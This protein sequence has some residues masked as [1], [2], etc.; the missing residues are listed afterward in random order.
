MVH[1]TIFTLLA[2]VKDDIFHIPLARSQKCPHRYQ[3]PRG[4]GF[5]WTAAQTCT[6]T[7]LCIAVRT[8]QYIVQTVPFFFSLLSYGPLLLDS[9]GAELFVAVPC[10]NIRLF[11]CVYRL[12]HCVESAVSLNFHKG[13]A[14][15]H[16]G[17]YEALMSSALKESSVIRHFECSD[18]IEIHDRIISDFYTELSYL[19]TVRPL[20]NV[21]MIAHYICYHY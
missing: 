16:F 10:R 19:C 6:W 12:H 17:I 7:K 18:V 2:D 11:C 4:Q 9:Q 8:V 5:Q 15:T 20:S 3:T 1:T 13:R 21:A 14:H